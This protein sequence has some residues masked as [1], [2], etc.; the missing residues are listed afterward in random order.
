MAWAL[1]LTST[2]FMLIQ[3]PV[4]LS[5]LLIGTVLILCRLGRRIGYPLPPGPDNGR[6]FPRKSINL[7]KS[8]QEFEELTDTYG[9]VCCLR[10]WSGTIVVIGRL[11]AAMEI[12]ESQGAS[13]VDRPKSIAAGEILSHNMRILVMSYGKRFQRFRKALHTHL[14]PSAVPA[15]E[16]LQTRNARELILDILADPDNH[17]EHVKRFAVSFILCLTYGKRI[18]TSLKDPHILGIQRTLQRMSMASQP[19][20]FFVDYHRLLSYIPAFTKKLHVWHQEELSLYRSHLFA[21]EEAMKTPNCPPSFGRFLIE[22]KQCHGLNDDEMAYLAG[23][24]F[25]AGSETTANSLGFI[26][27]A[28]ACFPD[29]QKEVQEEL[30]RVVGRD[31]PPTFEHRK[32]LPKVSAFVLEVLRWRAVSGTGFAHVATKDIVWNGYCIPEGSTVIGNHWSICRDPEAFP[33]PGE[34]QLNRWLDKDDQLIEDKNTLLFGFGRRVCPGQYVANRSLFIA[35]AF[36]LWAF[37][38]SQNSKSSIDTTP[39]PGAVGIKPKPFL[40]QYEPRIDQ[41]EELPCQIG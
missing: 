15:Y 16:P 24:M 38:I 39:I 5:V 34:F 25:G 23:S 30:D 36:L 20:A 9:P 14:Q 4:L 1:D 2:T 31:L 19:G 29:A 35:T 17:L 33:D 27:M 40:A 26:I 12:M 7:F 10:T 28:A 3:N 41:L 11:Q 18:S 21:V 13:L 22:N 32:L 37:Q 6:L 8:W